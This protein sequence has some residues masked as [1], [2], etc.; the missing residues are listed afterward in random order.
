METSSKPNKN[1]PISG[2]LKKL[3]RE[4]W[5]SELLVSGFSIFLLINVPG[6]LNELLEYVEFNLDDSIGGSGNFTEIIKIF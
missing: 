5:E 1:Q 2:W 6:L 4:S 3:Q